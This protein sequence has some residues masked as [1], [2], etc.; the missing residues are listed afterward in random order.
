MLSESRWKSII[1]PLLEQP[2]AWAFQG[3]LTYRTPVDWVLLGVHGEGSGLQPN[4]VYVS[5]VLMPLFVPADH[6]TLDHSTRVPHGSATFGLD[7]EAAFAS[8]MSLA[9]S[10]LP[11]QTEA[12]DL[13]AASTSEESAYAA[14]LLGDHKQAERMLVEPFHPND[15]RPFVH[16]SRMR[17]EEVL[18]VL[19]SAGPDSA[20]RLLWSWRDHTA[21]SLGLT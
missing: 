6:L 21:A 11:S 4:R 16:H 9:I 2:P 10:L 12:L 20:R 13:I 7:D 15:D 8:A 1:L 5:T 3:K 19:R 17:R 14:F 18:H